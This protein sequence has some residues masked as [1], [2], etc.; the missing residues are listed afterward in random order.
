MARRRTQQVRGYRSGGAVT[1]DDRLPGFGMSEEPEEAR[2]DVPPPSHAAPPQ[3]HPPADD[4]VAR[5]LA[6]QRL[7]EQMQAEQMH[8]PAAEH[9]HPQQPARQPMTVEQWIDAQP[10]SDRRKDFVREHRELLLPQN[11]EAVESYWKM[12]RRLGITDEAEVDDYVWRG[13]SFEQASRRAAEERARNPHREAA[14]DAPASSA[15]PQARRE[16]IPP[17][18]QPS[19]APRRSMPMTAPV[20]REVPTMNGRRMSENNRLSPE[21]RDMA[22]KA[23]PDRPDLPKMTNHE[24]ELMYLRNREKYRRMLADGTY[25]QQRQ[26]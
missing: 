1:T 21:E 24:K 5:A 16:P 15:P 3:Q 2:A 17:T 26:R 18:L 19:A 11:A 20:T 10:W 9:A 25:D 13:L 23:I 8:R 7:A 4:A 14:E 6:G 22:H 12:A